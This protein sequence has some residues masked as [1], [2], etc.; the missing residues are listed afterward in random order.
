MPFLM[1][2]TPNCTIFAHFRDVIL[3]QAFLYDIYGYSGN[4]SP[5]R[6]AHPGPITS[7]AQHADV[8][9]HCGALRTGM[10]T[11]VYVFGNQTYSLTLS[12]LRRQSVEPRTSFE[13]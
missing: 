6:P 13:I 12:Q 11:T 8:P 5:P 3:I 1:Y 2:S 4:R 10:I 7:T 9:L